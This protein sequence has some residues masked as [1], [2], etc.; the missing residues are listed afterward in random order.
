M[1]QRNFTRKQEI[2]SKLHFIT[3]SQIRDSFVQSEQD[4]SDLS[5]TLAAAFAWQGS[6]F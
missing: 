4:L 3:D 2:P 5:P 6:S 1:H